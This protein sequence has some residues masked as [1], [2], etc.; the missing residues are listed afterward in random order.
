[1]ST[2]TSRPVAAPTPAVHGPID[3]SALVTSSGVRVKVL[4]DHTID[5]PQ[6]T[7]VQEAVW[8]Y[9]EETL[10]IKPAGDPISLYDLI[11]IMDRLGFP[12]DYQELR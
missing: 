9:P 7:I 8:P 12:V 2:L 4:E 1:M 10:L 5:P 3:L 6:V 11:V